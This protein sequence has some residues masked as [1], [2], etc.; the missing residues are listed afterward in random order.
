MATLH[1]KDF[2]DALHDRLQSQ[3]ERGGR[4]LSQEVIHLLS[5]AVE[6]SEAT[7]VLDLKGLGKELW[8]EIDVARYL[9]DERGSWDR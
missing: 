2:P 6:E 4:S 3:A 8:R 9:D 1:I 7:S 5:R